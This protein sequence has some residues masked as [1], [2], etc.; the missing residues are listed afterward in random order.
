MERI[1]TPRSTTSTSIWA[2]NWAM[3]PPPPTSTAPSSPVCQYTPFSS[4]I[5]ITLAM[6]SALA[7]LLPDFPLAPVYFVRTQPLL[8][9]LEF[10]SSYTEAK[11]G[12][13]AAFTSEDRHRDAL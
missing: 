11:V 2:T 7:S 12:S 1:G 10:L 5:W 3:V 9:A 13:Y 6:V 4:M 8:M